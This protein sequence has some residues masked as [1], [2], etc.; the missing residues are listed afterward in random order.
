MRTMPR[1]LARLLSVLVLLLGGPC[2]A[3]AAE[4]V[5]ITLIVTSDLDTIDTGTERGGFARL[6]ALVGRER[7]ERRNVVVVHAGDAISPSLLS[8]FDQGL[9]IIEL[10]NQIAPD[11]F[12]PGNHEFD[13][14]PSVFLRRVS[15]AT[16]PVVSANLQGADGSSLPGVE[17]SRLLELDGVRVGFVGLTT[18]KTS[19]KASPEDLRILGMLDALASEAATL[20]RAGADLIVAA[21]HA[22]AREDM[23][24]FRSRLADVVLS[25]DDHQLRVVYDGVTVLAESRDQAETVAI[26]DLA[27]AIGERD[28]KRTVAWEPGF[29]IIDTADVAPDP[30]VA[31]RI[32]ALQL[33]LSSELDATLGVTAIP[34]DSRRMTVRSGESAIGNLVADAMR[35]ATGAD[36]AITNGG[37]IRGD[38]QYP[39]GTELSRRDILAELPFGNKT[40]V[41]ELTGA[42]ILAAIENGLS[43]VEEGSGRFPHVSGLRVA[44]DLARPP[45]QRVTGIWFGATDLDLGATYRVA[46]NDFM[47]R[48]GDGY[49]V[50][51]DGTV[52]VSAADGNLMASEVM[53]YVRAKGTAGAAPSGRLTIR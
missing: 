5:E 28:G 11:V 27:V 17:R 42:Q 2:A 16:F 48:G 26:V 4:R 23:L 19:V 21:V 24:L 14:G 15:E 35:A 44:A 47:Y 43:A 36:I 9:H 33:Q 12:V 34:L 22:D 1:R 8:G 7:A 41:V 20:R 46:T 52:I 51:A 39:A 38:R 3:E 6:A 37:G 49:N 32:A 50:F 30:A 13:F 53:A 45:G 25:G 10:L 29:R 18:A 40:V 31:D